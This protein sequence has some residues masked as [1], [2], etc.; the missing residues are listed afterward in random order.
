VFDRRE[1]GQSGGRLEHIT[2]KHYVDQGIGLLDHLKIEQAHFMGGCMGCSPVMA[3]AVSNPDRILSQ[4]LF[5]PVG[6]ARY[7]LNA[8]H[9]FS[10]HLTFVDAQGLKAV[11][12]KAMEGKAFGTDPSAGPWASVI[13]RDNDFAKKLLDQDLETYKLIV[14]A[15][16]RGLI[17]RD[18][19][20]GVEAEDL[21]C[22][23]VPTFIVPGADAS[24]ARS[25]A[26][27]AT[28]CIEG[29]E[30]WD[31][32]VEQQTESKFAELL[33]DFIGRNS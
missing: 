1:A 27:F 20:P 17:D 21:L 5:W 33:L 11:V 9:R 31:V 18:S 4:T 29:A 22:L 7:R 13:Y 3:A 24:H 26:Y 8:Q 19:L 28:E 16:A 10:K 25:A 6:G 15:I 30:C 12:D 2:W 32:P 23:R 14:S